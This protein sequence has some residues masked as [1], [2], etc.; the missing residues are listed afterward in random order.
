MCVSPIVGYDFTQ[1]RGIHPDPKEFIFHF[2]EKGYSVSN[3]VLGINIRQVVYE[4]FILSYKFSYSPK[5]VNIFKRNFIPINGFKY[6]HI[7]NN[8][9]L[10]YNI[11]GFLNLGLGYNYNFLDNLRYTNGSRIV[12]K[13]EDIV[14]ESGFDVSLLFKY[15]RFG[16]E[17]YYYDGNK[18]GEI[19]AWG[20]Y[21]SI[22]PLN[23]FGLSLLYDLKIFKTGQLGKKT[24]DINCPKF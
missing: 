16:L 9:K 6:N 1:L 8:F 12:D 24:R 11:G 2:E 20:R 4:N 10:Y 23:S 22:L 18:V 14:K 15:K 3:I 21:A 7:C 5:K 13:F 17:F 19:K